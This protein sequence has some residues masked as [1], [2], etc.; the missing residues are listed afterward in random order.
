MAKTKAALEFDKAVEAGVLRAMG[1]RDFLRRVDRAVIN[2]LDC[3]FEEM[4]NE[5]SELGTFVQE[6]VSIVLAKHEK[7]YLEMISTIVQRSMKS[8]LKD[9]CLDF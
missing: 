9:A 8:R 3:L 6:Q 5:N 7:E 4:D 1:K 2:E